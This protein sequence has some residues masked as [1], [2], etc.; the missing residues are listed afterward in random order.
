MKVRLGQVRRSLG[1]RLDAGQM[2]SCS[3]GGLIQDRQLDAGG[4]QING[5]QYQL[6]FF[7]LS[8]IQRIIPHGQGLKMKFGL[9]N[10]LKW[11]G[12]NFVSD[13]EQNLIQSHFKIF[14]KPNFIF[15]LH[16]T[17]S[18]SLRPLFDLILI[19]LKLIK[20]IPRQLR[21][22]G[23]ALFSLM[24][25]LLCRL[26]QV[27]L[28]GYWAGGQMQGR[29]LDSGQAVRCRAGSQI[30]GWRF[31]V[32]SYGA[33]PMKD[34]LGCIRWLLGRQLDAGQVVHCSVLW[35]SCYEG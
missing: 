7:L 17:C 33:L 27:R 11:V 15:K 6:L 28:D 34:R 29:R 8:T 26:G 20:N 10:I 14:F 13:S 12:L 16:R 4:G 24:E 23:G 1:R 2:V 31:T 35:R 9:K 19:Q 22:A 21:R 30:Q 32:W 25:E 5:R 3:A 18:N